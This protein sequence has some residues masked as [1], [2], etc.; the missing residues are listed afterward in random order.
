MNTFIQYS[1]VTKNDNFKISA[2]K[3]PIQY[4]S[5]RLGSCFFIHS[6][7]TND[8]YRVEFSS[9]ISKE[10]FYPHFALSSNVTDKEVEG[11]ILRERKESK[12][13]LKEIFF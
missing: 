13:S 6:T 7:N 1:L 5:H 11:I 8:V 2:S 9:Q 4:I 12:K 10:P 3:Q